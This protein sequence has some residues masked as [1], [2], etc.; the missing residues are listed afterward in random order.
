M[1]RP[2]TWTQRWILGGLI[3]VA[4]FGAVLGQESPTTPKPGQ[5]G[6]D[7]TLGEEQARSTI[8]EGFTLRRVPVRP[9]DPDSAIWEANPHVAFAL[10]QRLQRPLLLL[11][12]ADWNAKCLKL[13]EEVFSTKSFNEFAKEQVVICYLNYPRNRTDAP[14]SQR[15]WKEQFKVRGYPN[16]LVFNPEGEVVREI[17]GYTPGK[18]VTYFNQLK[19]VVMPLIASVE[20]R[21]AE[22]RKRGFREWKNKKGT[23]LFAR[24]VQRDE[25]RVTLEGVNRKTWT[26]ETATLADNDQAL[27]NSFPAIEELVG[28]R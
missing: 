20:E 27:V 26:V 25:E 11:F 15:R 12:T 14:M 3:A 21:K 13:S 1:K 28:D 7:T 10:A 23:P 24:F 17:T 16:L 2:P 9:E 6:D 18:P 22:L 5:S 8:L 19:S 4:G